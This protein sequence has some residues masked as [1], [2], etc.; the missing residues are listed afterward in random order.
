EIAAHA[1][2]GLQLELWVQIVKGIVKIPALVE[3]VVH[4]R[5]DLEE[6]EAERTLPVQAE[7]PVGDGRRAVERQIGGAGVAT[8]NDTGGRHRARDAL[9]VGSKRRPAG[10]PIGILGGA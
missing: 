2:I 4:E 8:A 3:Q 9:A 7:V 1:R 10:N 5:S 6:I